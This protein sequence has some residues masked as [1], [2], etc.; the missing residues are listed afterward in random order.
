MILVETVPVM[1]GWGM[2]ESGGGVKF[3]YHIVDTL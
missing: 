2:K 1:R 3:N